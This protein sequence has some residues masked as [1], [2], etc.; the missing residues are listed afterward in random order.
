M[1]GHQQQDKYT[2]WSNTPKSQVLD[3]SSGIAI[4][5]AAKYYA[6]GITIFII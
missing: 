5:D 4:L 1:G 2:F 3:S 6:K